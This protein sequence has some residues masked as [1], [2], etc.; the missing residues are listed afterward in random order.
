MNNLSNKVRVPN[1]T[2][3]LNLRLFNIITGINESQ[4][5][6]KHISCKCKCRFNRRKC[7]S[8]EWSNND[9]CRCECKKLHVCEKDYVRNPST[10][11]CENEKYLANIMDN[12]A[13]MC[14]EAV[15]S[16]EEETNFN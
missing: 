10:C 3:D 5:L 2:E 11:N 1:K 13:I 7:N 14:D 8:G 12:S 16:Y 15:K 9:K 6:T 4:T